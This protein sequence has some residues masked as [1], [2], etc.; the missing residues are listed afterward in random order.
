M[1]LVV[2]SKSFS[3]PDDAMETIDTKMYS[4]TYTKIPKATDIYSYI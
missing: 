1:D 4:Y 3:F 2:D